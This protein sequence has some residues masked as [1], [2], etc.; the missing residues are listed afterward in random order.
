M[1]EQI[2]TPEKQPSKIEISNLSGAEF[3]KLL[4]RMLKE[5]S[6]DLYSIKKIQSG[7]KYTL[8]KIKNNLQENNSRVDEDKSQIND[9]EHKE[10][11]NNQSEQQEEKRIQKN[12]E[13]VSSLW[14]NFKRSNICIIGVPEGEE[15]EQE[16][17]NLFEKIMKDNFPN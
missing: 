9:L 1:K 3:K 13:N 6:E 12:G 17:G 14:D 11:I 5:L 10:T 4:I 7:K 8:I 16:I 2:K 15:K